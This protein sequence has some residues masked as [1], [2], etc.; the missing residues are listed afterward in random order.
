MLI[1]VGQIVKSTSGRDRGRFFVIVACEEQAVYL[2]DG[3]LHRLARP[4]KKNPKHLAPTARMVAVDQMTTD[5][6]LRRLLAAYGN[7][8]RKES[9]EGG[10]K[11]HV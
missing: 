6:A 9:S 11:Q 7:E 10:G 1:Q 3:K 8:A 4:K 5:A 2:A